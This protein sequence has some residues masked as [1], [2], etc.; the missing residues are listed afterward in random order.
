LTS[1][2]S[3]TW[4]L[5]DDVDPE[6]CATV[7][8]ERV[9][10]TAAFAVYV[11][12]RGL[13]QWIVAASTA[14]VDVIGRAWPHDGTLV[15]IRDSVGL[16]TPD[17]MPEKRDSAVVGLLRGD[18]ALSE[19]PLFA[20]AFYV[21]LPGGAV[22][23]HLGAAR[24]RSELSARERPRVFVNAAHPLVADLE[25]ALTAADDGLK[26]QLMT[27]LDA[28]CEAVIEDT[29]KLAPAARWTTLR[30]DYRRLTGSDIADVVL[31][32]IEV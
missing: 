30:D 11:R 19:S 9:A 2:E 7:A 5:L 21:R 13:R 25:R 20:D 4:A 15:R 31:D 10:A 14:E 22:P 6:E 29:T 18:Y 27:W 17:L 12:A 8:P 1:A 26:R 28:V 32:R 24:R 16:F 3:E 23:R